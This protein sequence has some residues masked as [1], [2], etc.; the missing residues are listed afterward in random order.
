MPANINQLSTAN[1]FQQ[2]LVATQSLIGIANNLTNGV[3]GTFYANTNMVVGGD[4]TVT[5]NI[6]LDSIGFNDMNVAGNLVVG[7]T[8]NLVKTNIETANITSFT[9]TANTNIYNTISS[10]ANGIVDT[11][12]AFAIALG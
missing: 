2:W 5:G 6:T 4:L 10:S 9:G 8:A 11:A 12:L 7:G 3:G 1:T